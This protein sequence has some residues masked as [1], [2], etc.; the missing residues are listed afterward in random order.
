MDKIA[1]D[2]D[3]LYSVQ[4][5]YH[6]ESVYRIYIN[7]PSKSDKTDVFLTDYMKMC[8]SK[9]IP[10]TMKGYQDKGA[11]SKDNTVLYLFEENL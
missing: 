10:Y 5:I 3:F 9:K 11:T 8:I 2:K 6:K 7:T 1:D 4:N